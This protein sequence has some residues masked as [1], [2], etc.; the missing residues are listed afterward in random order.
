MIVPDQVRVGDTW[1][2]NGGNL[3]GAVAV[4]FI[5]VGGETVQALHVIF[6]GTNGIE[7]ES[8][9]VSEWCVEYYDNFEDD[10]DMK[11]RAAV[12]TPAC[13]N[14]LALGW[15]NQVHVWYH[16][17]MPVKVLDER[18]T[19][20][21]TEFGYLMGH[22]PDNNLS[23]PDVGGTEGDCDRWH[24]NWPTG[25]DTEIDR[26]QPYAVFTVTQT[27]DEM[28]ATNIRTGATF[29]SEFS[30]EAEEL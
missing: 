24:T 26:L 27:S 9:G 14:N 20:N 19:I 25:P 6:R 18:V 13:N 11:G 1:L 28:T 16:R 3:V 17:G 22:N 4:D 29:A 15:I 23:A 2:D 21:V 12:Q 10:P 30:G 8:E 5:D 7:M